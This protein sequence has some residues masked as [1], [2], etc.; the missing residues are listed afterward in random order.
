MGNELETAWNEADDYLNDVLQLL[1]T[2]DWN[3]YETVNSWFAGA[4]LNENGQ[5]T[6]R[7]TL[8]GKISYNQL[9]GDINFD[10]EVNILDVILLVSFILGEPTDEYEYIAADI[11]QDN[12]LS[13]L[14]IVL[15]IDMILNP[16]LPEECYIIPE[17]GPCD[18]ICPTYYYNQETNQCEEFITGC[19][20]VE[21][22]ITL[23]D[24]QNI[25]E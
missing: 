22:F 10:G 23:L 18:G 24:C 16:D 5:W 7:L 6:Y 15:L 17:V 2:L 4:E 1:N 12:E 20:G 14:D 25:C 8:Q 13:I 3:G 21:A 19:C 9:I 11:N